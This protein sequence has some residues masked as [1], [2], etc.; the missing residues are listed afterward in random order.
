MFDMDDVLSGLSII[1]EPTT[2][3]IAIAGVIL[4]SVLGAIPGLSATMAI[5]LLVPFTF[6]LNPVQAIVLLTAMYKGGIFGG[7]IAA[8]LLNTPGTSAAAATAIDGHQLARQG[9]ARKA[10]KMAVVSSSLGDLF[11][12][13]V[14]IS[15]AGVIANF[16]L[17]FG[18]PEYTALILFA[19][20]VILGI[21]QKS[22]IKGMLA[23]VLGVFIGTIGYDPSTGVPRLSFG[24][25]E[26]SGGFELVPLLIG[27][28]AVSQVFILMEE[29]FLGKN[30]GN[31]IMKPD[32]NSKLTWQEFKDS[33]LIYLQSGAIGTF[34]GSLPG[35]G[36]TVAA[37][38]GRNAGKRLAKNPKKYGKGA[39]EG[40]AAPE[41]SNSAVGSSNLIP[42][43][44]LGI[45]GDAEAALILSVLIIHG[46]TPGPT[47][48]DTDG[49]II[50]GIYFG[51][52]ISICVLFLF[53]WY[54]SRWV[55]KVRNI[56]VTLLIPA[57]LVLCVAGSYG[58]NQNMFDV[59]TMF[60][61][62]V[63][64]YLMI[65]FQ[66]PTTALLIG[67]IL[68]PIFESSLR[69]SMILSNNNPIIFFQNP[70]SLVFII[71]TIM[72]VIFYI[73]REVKSPKNED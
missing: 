10:I 59:Q 2:I 8:I 29:T 64:G 15:I 13:I 57:I 43:I 41:A 30:T 25:M 50:Y 19:F 55:V 26:L 60:I 16:A 61:F 3:L 27:L 9:K 20:T 51:I 62:A 58:M 7:S 72:I 4:G 42:L 67:F 47:V 71:I 24:S 48:F 65:K 1:L 70:I 56:N 68:G 33:R 73:I 44:S 6:T 11:A 45:P 66:F 31:D 49:P 34:V 12:V 5:A 21:S 35:L 18:P 69:Q 17:E 53:N 28:L 23:T 32:D 52:L 14:L 38:L 36:P 46:I 54:A 22:I 37:F 40:V 63:I 39:L